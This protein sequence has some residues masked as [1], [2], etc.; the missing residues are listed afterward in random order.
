MLD[1]A[2]CF[3]WRAPSI[4][5]LALGMVTRAMCSGTWLPPGPPDHPAVLT[6]HKAHPEVQVLKNHRAEPEPLEP[7]Y[8][9]R[10]EARCRPD[11]GHLMLAQRSTPQARRPGQKRPAP[12]SSRPATGGGAGGAEEGMPAAAARTRPPRRP[13]RSRRASRPRR[14]C[15]CSSWRP[16]TATASTPS[17]RS[18]WEG[19]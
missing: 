8:C 3:Y 6:I 19:S 18:K 4:A 16:P 5:V 17:S 2:H 9:R 10:R 12:R 13:W 1:V 14:G 15:S 7:W 11:P